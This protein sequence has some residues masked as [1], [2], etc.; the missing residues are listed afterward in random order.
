MKKCDVIGEWEAVALPTL[1][2]APAAR[3]EN[4][5]SVVVRSLLDDGW[6]LHGTKIAMRD[7][8]QTREAPICPS[9]DC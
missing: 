9:S 7:V 4:V 2:L 6:L 5:Y 3:D 1:E 8:T